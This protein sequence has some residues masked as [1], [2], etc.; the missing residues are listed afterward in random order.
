MSA[1]FEV[2]PRSA[3]PAEAIDVARRG[4]IAHLTHDGKRVAA[5]VPAA[6]ASAIVTMIEALDTADDIR[7]AHQAR[8]DSE[9]S[10]PFEDVMAEYANDLIAY[11]AD[12]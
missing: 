10:I 4:E 8:A 11:P 9:P 1:V 12:Q 3:A 6:I 2:P 7:A 5:V